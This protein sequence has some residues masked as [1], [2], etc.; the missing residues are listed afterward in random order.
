M[1]VCVFLIDVTITGLSKGP[2]SCARGREH[3]SCGVQVNLGPS[4]LGHKGVLKS[5][6][7]VSHFSPALKCSCTNRLSVLSVFHLTHLRGE[8]VQ[9]PSHTPTT[10]FSLAT[11]SIRA[12]LHSTHFHPQTSI[13]SQH[14]RSSDSIKNAFTPPHLLFP[15]S[16]TLPQLRP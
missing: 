9:K 10:T 3:W 11:A 15:C 13:I 7:S 2:F 14:L 1:R 12:F 6:L 5:A 8:V 4:T 16:L